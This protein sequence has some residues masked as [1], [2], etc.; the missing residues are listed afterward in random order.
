MFPLV[1]WLKNIMKIITKK[2]HKLP[3]KKLQ[4]K[5]KEK[6]VCTYLLVKLEFRD[7]FHDDFCFVFK[8]IKLRPWSWPRSPCC[9]LWRTW[10]SWK[11]RKWKYQL[12]PVDYVLNGVKWTFDGTSE[13]L[14]GP[15]SGKDYPVAGTRPGPGTRPGIPVPAFFL[16]GPG[17]G[18]IH[19]WRPHWGGE[20]G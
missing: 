20:G 12:N 5:N 7:D 1:N 15:G 17:K 2:H 11:G 14:W 13:T 9:W 3:I 4:E 6:F 19:T 16:R 18:G 8:S 10:G